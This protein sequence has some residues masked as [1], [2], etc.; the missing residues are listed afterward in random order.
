MGQVQQ[1]D[2]QVKVV[3][4]THQESKKAAGEVFSCLFTCFYP[5]IRNDLSTWLLWWVY[6]AVNTACV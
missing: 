2:L 5:W 4:I 6:C 1:V 3:L